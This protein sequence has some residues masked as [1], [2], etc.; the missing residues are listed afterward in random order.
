MEKRVRKIIFQKATKKRIEKKKK[1]H[2]SKS[3]LLLDKRCIAQIV[4]TPYSLPRSW[5]KFPLK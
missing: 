3:C 4:V 5:P 2:I 1:N